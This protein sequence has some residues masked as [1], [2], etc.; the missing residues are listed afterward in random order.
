MAPSPCGCRSEGAGR[1]VGYDEWPFRPSGAPRRSA[2]APVA[3]KVRRMKPGPTHEERADE[4]RQPKHRRGVPIDPASA[5]T[6]AVRA[7]KLFSRA[8][9][10]PHW[11][12]S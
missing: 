12:A 3:P 5:V 6:I 4:V 7:E 11:L 10:S 8:R 2:D 1:T 9:R